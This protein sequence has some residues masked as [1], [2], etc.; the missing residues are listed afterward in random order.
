[1]NTSQVAAVIPCYNSY[2]KIGNVVA[3]VKKYISDVIVVDDGSQDQSAEYARK[4]GATVISLDKNKVVGKAT[5][6][7]IQTAL[8]IK[9]EIIITLDA[10]AAHNPSNILGL[11][12]HHLDSG[13]AL[14]I[15]NRW[16]DYNVHIPNQKWWANQF[17]STLINRISSLEIPDVA[18]GFRVFNKELAENLV[19]NPMACGFGF[20]YQ[21]IFIA[22]NLGEI[23]FAPIDVRYDANFLLATKQHELFHLLEISQKYCTDT[24]LQ[25]VIKKMIKEVTLLKKIDLKLR[26]KSCNN[27]IVL[28]PLI[29]QRSYLFQWQHPDF[30]TNTTNFCEI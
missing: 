21:Q 26:N 7:G 19:S 27:Y 11:L 22:K 20:I 6:I 23:G 5:R 15:G 28:F 29:S 17:A 12:K 14:T 8:E 30:V 3:D 9:K 16:S 2:A 18:C 10:D 1:M 13:C 4:S 25:N 24:N